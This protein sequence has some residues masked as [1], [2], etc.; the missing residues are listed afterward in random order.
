MGVIRGPH[1][2]RDGLIINLDTSSHKSYP[3]TGTSVYDTSGNEY[4]LTIDGATYN[5][6]TKAIDFDGT[7]NYAAFSNPTE[8]NFQPTDSFT[9]TAVFSLA[10][11]QQFDGN[12]HDTHVTLFGKGSTGNSVGIGLTR[13]KTTEQLRIYAGS[14]AVGQITEDHNITASTIYSTTYS[15][16]PTSQKL[17]VNGKFISSSSTSAGTSGTFENISWKIFFPSAV[18]GG[19]GKYAE[20]SIYVARMYD[21]ELSANEVLQNF[22]SVSSR[23]NL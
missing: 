19:N 4:T 8:L 3:G 7:D 15:Y 11:I 18:P 17:Y 23:F 16:T 22:N 2:V 1:I 13:N 20:G 5:S 12:A 14:R 10:A 21:R 6:T 9:L